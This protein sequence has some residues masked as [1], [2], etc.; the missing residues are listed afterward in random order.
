VS[1]W[2]MEDRYE[3]LHFICQT[4]RFAAGILNPGH[5][6]HQGQGDVF[7]LSWI[8]INDGPLPYRIPTTNLNSLYRKYSLSSN[9]YPPFVRMQCRTS[10]VQAYCQCKTAS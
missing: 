5:H 10:R 3:G 8:V 6:R 4:L 2:G 9:T 1:T 7:K